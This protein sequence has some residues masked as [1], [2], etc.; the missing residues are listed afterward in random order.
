M[1]KIFYFIF[2]VLI[3]N[4]AGVCKAN[5]TIVPLP[6]DNIAVYVDSIDVE[7]YKQVVEQLQSPYSMYCNK[8][9]AIVATV[10][11]GFLGG[12]RVY[13]GTEPWVPVVYA[14]TL[15]GGFGILPLAD[16]GVLIFSKNTNKFCG[17][18]QIIMWL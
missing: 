6:V 3:L 14:L 7:E 4:V 15:G 5:D 1:N 11:T 16:L 12:H 9:T 13:M 17:N 8:T 2:T 10:L 18:S